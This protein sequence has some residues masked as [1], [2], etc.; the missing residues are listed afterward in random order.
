VTRKQRRIAFV[1][2]AFLILASAT[3]LILTALGD[4][5]QFFY[6]PSDAIEKNPPAGRVI[7]L[8]GLVAQGSVVR[9]QGET[10]TFRITD[11]KTDVPVTYTGIPPD[12]FREGQGVIAVGA[13]D[14][15]RM[16]VA[17]QI[18][19]AHDETYM[20]PEVAKALK[21]RGEWRGPDMQ[22][23]PEGP[24]GTPSPEKGAGS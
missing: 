11:N 7:R 15:G 23:S 14:S 12:L 22:G 18:L 19:T 10:V 6:G 13:F 3:G 24:A 17:Q 5:M 1:A 2:G 9:N 20:P 8:G 21:E 4:S 16:F